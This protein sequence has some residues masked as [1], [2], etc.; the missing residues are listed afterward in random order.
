MKNKKSSI[1]LFSKSVLLGILDADSVIELLYA[2]VCSG[3]VLSYK[4]L[5]EK[6]F[7]RKNLILDIF[8]RQFV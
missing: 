4:N 3:F 2:A 1:N 6:T 7:F 8:Q 5:L